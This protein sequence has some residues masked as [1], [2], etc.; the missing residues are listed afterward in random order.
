MASE[1]GLARVLLGIASTEDRD[2]G[3]EERCGRE[4]SGDTH[5]ITAVAAGILGSRRQAIE[6]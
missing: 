2:S 5:L 3:D 6:V 4:R 1:Q